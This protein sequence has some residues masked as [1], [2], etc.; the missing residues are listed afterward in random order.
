[1]TPQDIILVSEIER[2]INLTN[3]WEV[4]EEYKDR[5]VSEEAKERLHW[6]VTNYWH[7]EEYKAGML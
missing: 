2:K 4:E 6:L 3:Y 1:M 5:L 7:K